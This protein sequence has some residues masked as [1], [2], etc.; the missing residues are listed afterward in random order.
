MGRTFKEMLIAGLFP[1]QGS[2]YVG[3]LTHLKGFRATAEVF[4]IISEF[5]QRDIMSLALEGP[6]KDLRQPLNAQLSVF[7]TSVCYWNL[8]KER[9]NFYAL[10]GHSLG[11]YSALYAANSL[12]LED[13]ISVIIEAHKAIEEICGKQKWT[14]TAVIGLKFQDV[15]RIC[16]RV[17]DV[18]VANINS[19]TQV[20]LSGKE[21][22]V[23]G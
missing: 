20:V 7:G 11:F 22:A 1:G 5:A 13:C 17:G 9:F 3:M 6:D 21:D 12:K 18:F 14:M 10:S 16:E 4:E 8:L 15:E 2:E 19:S 23:S